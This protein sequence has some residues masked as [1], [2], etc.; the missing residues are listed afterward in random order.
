M[1]HKCVPRSAMAPSAT[2]RIK[3]EYLSFENA[4]ENLDLRFSRER[5]QM[6][7]KLAKLSVY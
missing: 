2:Q 5:V 3:T 7:R 4:T 6:P 1:V